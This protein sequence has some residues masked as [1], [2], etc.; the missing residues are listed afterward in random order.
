[1][2]GEERRQRAML[3]IVEPG[4]QLSPLFDEMYSAI[5]Q[6]SISPERLLK[7]SLLIALYTVPSQRMF[8]EQFDYDLLVHRYG[9]GRAELRPF[10]LIA[11][12][13]AVFEHDVAS[14]FF[15]R[16]VAPARSLQLL[17][18]EHFTVDSTLGEAWTSL[19]SRA[20]SVMRCGDGGCKAVCRNRRGQG[21][22]G[23]GYWAKRRE[24]FSGQRRDRNERVA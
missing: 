23:R 15:T 10:D 13:R 3:M 24:L 14:E 9:C 18:D 2:R 22:V 11:Q 19:K 17:S 4:D 20:S 7:A 1:M 8:S 12:L 16:V 5:G 21:A 6:R